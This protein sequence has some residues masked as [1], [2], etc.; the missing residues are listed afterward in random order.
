MVHE[1][2]NREGVKRFKVKGLQ[3]TYKDYELQAVS[4][5][6]APQGVEEREK[7][8]KTRQIEREIKYEGIEQWPLRPD[9][10]E[11]ETFIVLHVF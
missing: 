7:E 11:A 1:I 6:A 4:S 9:G 8:R 3:G 10:C 5:I 2:Q